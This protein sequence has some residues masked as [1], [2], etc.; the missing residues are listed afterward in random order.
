M[1][2]QIDHSILE[3]ALIGYE[4][5]RRK[6]EEAIAAIQGE[7]GAGSRRAIPAVEGAAPKPR[8]TMSAAARK[9]IA[10]AQKKR[11]AEFHAKEPAGKSVAAT[12]KAAPKKA[13]S[14]EVKRKRIAALAKARAAKAEKKAARQSAA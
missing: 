8:R 5:E 10:A 3:M 7:L 6:I 1:P 14:A 11:W 13:V 4:A 2:R 9:R 12:K